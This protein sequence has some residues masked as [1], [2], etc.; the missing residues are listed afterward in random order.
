MKGHLTAFLCDRRVPIG[1]EL[2]ASRLRPRRKVCFSAAGSE[3]KLR[4]GMLSSRLGVS[5]SAVAFYKNEETSA[6]NSS[7]MP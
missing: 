6:L 4:T 3:N 5:R 2:A 7:G 1:G